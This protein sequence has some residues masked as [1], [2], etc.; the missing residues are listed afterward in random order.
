[1]L[2]TDNIWFNITER[3]RG[4]TCFN[5]RKR[6]PLSSEQLC[7]VISSPIRMLSCIQPRQRQTERKT[8]RADER[9][10][11]TYWERVK[12]G[13]TVPGKRHKQ[14]R[15]WL[16]GHKQLQHQSKTLACFLHCVCVWDTYWDAYCDTPDRLMNN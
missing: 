10:R 16:R 3:V 11:C 6:G 5:F 7:D 14:I 4:L 15:N 8:H 2:P 1:M 13:D 9:R 12:T